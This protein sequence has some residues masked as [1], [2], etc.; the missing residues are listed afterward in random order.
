[1]SILT[2]TEAARRRWQRGNQDAGSGSGVEMLAAD[3]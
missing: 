3:L 1:V 2:V